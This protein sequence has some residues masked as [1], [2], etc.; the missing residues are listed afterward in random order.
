MVAIA[1]GYAHHSLRMT[2]SPGSQECDFFSSYVSR[3]SAP[4]TA[5]PLSMMGWFWGE[6]VTQG[7]P[8]AYSWSST[9]W[10]LVKRKLSAPPSAPMTT[11]NF[12]SN[13]LFGFAEAGVEAVS[14]GAAGSD[15]GAI[16]S[17]SLLW[18]ASRPAGNN[19]RVSIST[20]A[21][22]KCRFIPFLSSWALQQG[23]R[24]SRV[25]P[26]RVHPA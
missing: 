8:A 1:A 2:R 7:A 4:Y 15:S 22:V 26:G 24:Q 9:S 6:L 23:D 5:R 10:R 13:T 16:L 19:A 11:K 20:P 12:L 18:A 3:N 21:A 25:A 14:I 17:K